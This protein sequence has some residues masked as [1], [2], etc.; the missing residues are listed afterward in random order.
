MGS[1]DPAKDRY[2]N[3]DAFS[4]P[5]P[6]TIGNSPRTMPIVRG[7]A[8]YNEDFSV[9]KRVSFTES[10]Y[11]EFRTEI[12]NLFNR[13]VFGGPSTDVNSPDSFGL[14]GSQANTPR[15]IQLAIKFIF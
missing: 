4:Q 10:K 3:I 14:I 7:P 11:L 6:F 5:A 1:F 13:V 2:L 15:I 9:F 8:L 12:F